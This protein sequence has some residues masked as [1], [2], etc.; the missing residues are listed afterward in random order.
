MSDDEHLDGSTVIRR[1]NVLWRT[2]SGFLTVSSI[3]GEARTAEG[4]A[5]AIW[6]LLVRPITL[7]E[8]CEQLAVHHDIDVAQVRSDTMPFLARLFELGYVQLDDGTNRSP[9][10]G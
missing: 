7:E 10:D 1:A 5:A 9:S 3:D 6:E 8:L 2:A 4:P